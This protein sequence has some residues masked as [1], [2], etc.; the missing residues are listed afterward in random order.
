MGY[1]DDDCNAVEVVRRRDCKYF[2]FS[3]LYGE[4][5]RGKLGIVVP[6]DF[7]SYGERKDGD[8]NC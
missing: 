7:C 3:D 5:K 6:N 4:C 1:F 8:G 2:M